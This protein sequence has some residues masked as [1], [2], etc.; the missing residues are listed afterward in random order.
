ML[1]DDWSVEKK[2]WLDTWMGGEDTEP[3]LITQSDFGCVEGE[4]REW[5][6]K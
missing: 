4:E 1:I 2:A 3:S 6:K 5:G